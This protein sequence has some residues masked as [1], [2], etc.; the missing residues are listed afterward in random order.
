MEPVW[1]AQK[2]E[3]TRYKI[4][5]SNQESKAAIYKQLLGNLL[6][7]QVTVLW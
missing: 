7:N 3:N 1:Y 4:R 6:R 2:K 5:K